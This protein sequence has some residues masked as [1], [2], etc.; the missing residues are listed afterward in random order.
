MTAVIV[1]R[2]HLRVDNHLGVHHS[3]VIHSQ[4]HS[5]LTVGARHQKLG[6][7]FSGQESVRF[8]YL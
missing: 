2:R 6:D 1:R 4:V 8:C 3:V 5:L 7:G